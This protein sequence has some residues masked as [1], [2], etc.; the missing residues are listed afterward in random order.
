MSLSEPAEGPTR[1]WPEAM[2]DDRHS[3]SQALRVRPPTVFASGQ[4]TVVGCA[5]L[6]YLIV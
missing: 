4:L 5:F 6:S 3:H 1:C 2:S